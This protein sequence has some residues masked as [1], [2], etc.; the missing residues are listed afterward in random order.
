MK[1]ILTTVCLG[2]VLLLGFPRQ[3]HAYI[4]PGLGSLLL[5][6]LAAAFIS[7]MLF[8]GRL[9]SKLTGF[10]RKK[11]SKADVPASQTSS[12]EDIRSDTT[13]TRK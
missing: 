1:F 8:W 3:A 11:S 5:Q 13:E 12:P 10:F 2:L 4:D 7:L 6:G 9:R